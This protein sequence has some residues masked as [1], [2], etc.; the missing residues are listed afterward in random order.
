MRHF[1][2]HI[3]NS[4]GGQTWFY[5]PWSIQ[6]QARSRYTSA[7]CWPLSTYVSCWRRRAVLCRRS[8]RSRRCPADLPLRTGRRSCGSPALRWRRR[9]SVCSG[10]VQADALDPVLEWEHVQALCPGLTAPPSLPA[11]SYIQCPKN[12]ERLS[13]PSF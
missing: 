6:G 1:I 9:P 5:L 10:R 7:R 13:G 2:S 3:R 11:G 8:R 4:N 12:L